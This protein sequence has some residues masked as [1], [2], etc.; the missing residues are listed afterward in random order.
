MGTCGS[1]AGGKLLPNESR[2]GREAARAMVAEEERE[3][4]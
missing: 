4:A 2:R 1:G 3:G